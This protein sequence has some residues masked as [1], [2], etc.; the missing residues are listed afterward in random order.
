MARAKS[1]LQLYHEYITKK[2]RRAWQPASEGRPVHVRFMVDATGM[3]RDAV[4]HDSSGDSARDEAALAF[5]RA[6]TLKP[7]P[8]ELGER[9]GTIQI[10]YLF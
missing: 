4:V 6:Q 1:E 8:T 9:L 10:D 5:V 2:F 3:I 7:L